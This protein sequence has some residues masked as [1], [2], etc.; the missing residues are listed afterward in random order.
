MPVASQYAQ[1]R[2]EE[3]FNSLFEMPYLSACGGY[4]RP[5]VGFQFSI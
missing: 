5:Q 4:E 2:V 1:E 3:A